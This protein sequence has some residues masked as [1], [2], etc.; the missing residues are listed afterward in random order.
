LPV[1]FDGLGVAPSG[2]EANVS[3]GYAGRCAP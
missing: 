3:D 1:L 2:W